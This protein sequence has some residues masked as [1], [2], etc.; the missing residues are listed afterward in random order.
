MWRGDGRGGEEVGVGSLG[1]SPIPHPPTPPPPPSLTVSPP[2][3]CDG[4]VYVSQHS[5][6]STPTVIKCPVAGPHKFVPLRFPHFFPSFLSLSLTLSLS[7]SLFFCEN[8]YHPSN[9]PPPLEKPSPHTP[10]PVFLLFVIE[11]HSK[12]FLL[13]ALAA[14]RVSYPMHK[15]QKTQKNTKKHK[16]TKQPSPPP[17]SLY[18][19]PLKS[20]HL[21]PPKKTNTK[22]HTHPLPPVCGLCCCN[23]RVPLGSNALHTPLPP[24][25]ITPSHSHIVCLCTRSSSVYSISACTSSVSFFASLSLRTREGG[26]LQPLLPLSLSLP[27]PTLPTLPKI[28]TAVEA[29]LVTRRTCCLRCWMLILP[30]AKKKNNNKLP[31]PSLPP[32]L[33]PHPLPTTT[34]PIIA[35]IALGPRSHH[36]SEHTERDGNNNNNN[37]NTH[38]RPL[39]LTYH[40][41]T[42]T[43]LPPPPSAQLQPSALSLNLSA[44]GLPFPSHYGLTRLSHIRIAALFQAALQTPPPTPPHP[45]MAIPH[46]SSLHSTTFLCVCVCVCVL[47]VCVCVCVCLHNSGVALFA[48]TSL[49]CVQAGIR[50]FTHT[51]THTPPPPTH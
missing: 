1:P 27:P 33:P 5:Q 43:S 37:N 4:S 3:S 32:S 16:K 8:A 51:H 23:Q 7:L 6:S 29:F 30:E 12:T 25:P 38:E 2:S 45:N 11:P 34:F 40:T 18:L 13:F 15:T 28:H 42:T 46:T 14:P 48:G 31:P 24:P 26:I 10:A 17:P 39:V 36:P 22:K 44:D 19:C 50:V 49:G 21:F 9:P 35:H 20:P 41:T 47:R